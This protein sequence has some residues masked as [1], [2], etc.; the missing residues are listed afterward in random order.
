ME[1]RRYRHHQ[2]AHVKSLFG[3]EAPARAEQLGF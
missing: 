2:V 1:E 3:R